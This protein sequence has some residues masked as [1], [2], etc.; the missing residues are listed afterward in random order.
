MTEEILSGERLSLIEGRVERL[1]AGLDQCFLERQSHARLALLSI[2]SGHHMLMIGPPGTAKSLLARAVCR[3]IEGGRYFEYLLS[4][5]THPDE[6]FGPNEFD[7][8]EPIS[9]II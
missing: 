4:R 5:F 1:L 6:L 8:D 7:F 9:V 2:L 3:C